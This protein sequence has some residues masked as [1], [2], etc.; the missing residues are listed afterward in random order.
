MKDGYQLLRK[1]TPP[2]KVGGTS[3]RIKKLTFPMQ[4]QTVNIHTSMTFV[5]LQFSAVRLRLLSRS[6]ISYHAD[7]DVF[8]R[9]GG[10]I[11]EQ[12]PSANR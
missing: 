5:R 2:M 3:H 11:R 1:Q 10:I 4:L 12:F 6:T 7:I 9:D 8:F